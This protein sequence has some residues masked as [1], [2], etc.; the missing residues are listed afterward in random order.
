MVVFAKKGIMSRT[1]L[2]CF[3][4][5]FILSSCK[6]DTPDMA[7]Q[8]PGYA[9]SETDSLI[10][11]SYEVI[12]FE[13]EPDYSGEVVATLLHRAPDSS[14]K[15]AM[16]YIHGYGDYYFQY[17][18]G[19]F[20]RSL[21]YHFYALDL[22]KYGRSLL[23][24]QRPNYVRSMTEYFPDI[25]RALTYIQEAGQET[26]VL[27]GH[28]TGGLTASLYA[29]QGAKRADIDGLLL[30]SPF[31][32]FSGSGLEKAGI[33]LFAGL[34]RFNKKAYLPRE[35]TGLYG[36]S[37]HEDF[38]GEWDYNFTWKPIDGF[39]LYYS[40]LKAIRGGHK[41]VRKGLK[42]EMPV[43]VLHSDSS[44]VGDTLSPQALRMDA[45]L[46]VD[47]IHTRSENLGDEVTIEIVENAMHDVFLSRER[48]R[49]EAFRRTEAW[50]NA[51]FR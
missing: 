45:V 23:P 31:F 8:E 37:I 38:A 35:S 28:S 10:N 22:R 44:Y 16:L 25:D 50:L 40:W 27:N 11:Q 36:R 34:S 42:L 15:K 24:H 21:G 49:R 41:Q 46:D 2:A 6:T 30:N 20:F 5:I 1:L 7:Y 43:L 14:G 18:V 26:I 9:L 29:A 4:L 48:V 3:I 39:P 12:T 19:E 13:Q 17:H 32:A 47:L 33:S 51:Q